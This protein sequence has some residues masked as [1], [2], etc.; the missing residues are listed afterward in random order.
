MDCVCATITLL[1]RKF[2]GVPNMPARHSQPTLAAAGVIC[3][4]G[5]VMRPNGLRIIFGLLLGVLVA[6]MIG[7]LPRTAPPKAMALSPF[8]LRFS[9]ALPVFTR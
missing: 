5:L 1:I 8:T 2:L 4:L 9:P 6:V 3:G 7:A